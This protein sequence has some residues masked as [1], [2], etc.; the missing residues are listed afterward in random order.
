MIYPDDFEARLGFSTIRKD[1]YN[2]CT[3]QNAMEIS[4]SLHMMTDKKTII[5][6][7]KESEEM[8]QAMVF[9]SDFHLEERAD[10][11][12]VY[13]IGSN[14]QHLSVEECLNISTALNCIFS[15]QK[16]LSYSETSDK[17]PLLKL[18][19]D[20]VVIPNEIL[21]R[22]Y[23]I[24][25]PTTREVRDNASLRLS[26]IRRSLASKRKNVSIKLQSLLA[27]AKSNGYTDENAEISI[28]DGHAVIPVNASN[29]RKIQ[30]FLMGDSASGKTSFIEPIEVVELNN[31]ITE[32]ESEEREE[33]IR[34]LTDFTLSLSEYK[35]DFHVLSSIIGQIDFI[36][37]KA[38]LAIDMNANDVI[39][40]D[41]QIL[42]MRD[43]RHP[44][45][46]RALRNENRNIIPL[47][48]NLNTEKRILLV[49]GPNAG[50]KSVCLKTVGL[51]QYMLQ[52]GLLIPSL[53]NSEF[54]IFENILLDIGDQ[55]SID[56]DLSTYSSHLKNMRTFLKTADSKTL[57]LIDEFGGGTE[58][59]MGGAIAEA[60]LEKLLETKAFGVITTHY[61]NLKHF[62]MG[63]E[64]IENGAMTF[65]QGKIAPLFKLEQGELGNSFAF[66]IAKNIGLPGDVIENAK[67][68][69]APEHIALERLLKEAARD[70]RYWEKKREKIRIENKKLVEKQTILKEK[71]DSIQTRKREII[72]N[73]RREAGQIVDNATSAVERTI[74]EIKE[75]AADKDRTKKAREDLNKIR[76]ELHKKEDKQTTSKKEKQK[77]SV[78]DSVTIE[79]SDVIGEI[80]Q[81]SGNKA[82]VRFGAIIS[83]AQIS[84]LRISDKKP[85]L[86]P[87]SSGKTLDTLNR[88]AE[89]NDQ[90]DV[91]GMRTVDALEKVTR[92]IDD[93][94]LFSIPQ[95]RILHGKGEG[96][97]KEQIRSY[98]LS[99]GIAK[100]V[101]DEKVDL[102]GA[103]IT[104]VEF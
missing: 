42:S 32:L 23:Q 75:S 61:D 41:G 7:I 34:I 70:K 11:N 97:L 85:L 13:K 33:I 24:I 20:S 6:A 63:A 88:R 48:L 3:T 55:Q 93:A 90:I 19:A 56:D 49:S 92:F 79:G 98:I 1:L 87:I 95:V 91:R 65:D 77:L 94:L 82:M 25:D 30:G 80:L 14:G 86:K 12:C 51:L 74:R 96:I 57:F 69:I 22:I 39:I 45:L 27:S 28:R 66:E 58:P 50:G 26:E 68:K 43:A 99:E 103:G 8:R 89:F 15:L 16:F 53:Q 5:N 9:D 52:C 64:G 54:S 59:T 37:A 83:Q 72:G 47:N 102:G 100:N 29:K 78:G 38:M 18:H 101:H 46:E 62:A 76:E 60:V 67:G 71:E 40:E 2:R 81:T 73:A 36:A 21:K 104:V 84:M 35:D 31:A 10:C 44:L 4:S 17:Y